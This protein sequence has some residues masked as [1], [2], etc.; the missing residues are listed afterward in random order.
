MNIFYAIITG[1]C[2]K[3]NRNIWAEDTWLRRIGQ[4][5][6]YSFIEEGNSDLSRKALGWNTEPGHHTV[7]LRLYNFYKHIFKNWHNEYWKYD[8]I[9]FSDS[10]S[11]VYPKRLRIFLSNFSSVCCPL[12]IGRLNKLESHPW[13]WSGKN[14]NC[15]LA[16]FFSG[17][18]PHGE[19][20]CHGGGAGWA[21]NK[22]AI[23]KVAKFLS[24]VENPM[25]S[26]HY[27]LAH[28]MWLN[29]CDI[30]MVHSRRFRPEA[31]YDMKKFSDYVDDQVITHH[32]MKEEDFYYV[33]SRT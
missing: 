13:S 27:D 32:Y 17:K 6:D 25:M 9:F 33:Y 30:P 15:Q 10:D 20:I 31:Y 22:S 4:N 7:H 8:W 26:M 3:D 21:I 16:D 24:E 18:V 28:S 14:Y 5:D 23:Y 12:F 11:Y 29:E 19:F 1:S 2:F